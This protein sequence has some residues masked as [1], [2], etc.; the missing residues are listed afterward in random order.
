[1][2]FLFN[3]RM[4]SMPEGGGWKVSVRLVLYNVCGGRDGVPLAKII[5]MSFSN[6]LTIGDSSEI[7]ISTSFIPVVGNGRRWNLY[8]TFAKQSD[9][10]V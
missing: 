3:D 10:S 4:S 5:S 6:S 7:G 9:K 2:L 1:M 8:L